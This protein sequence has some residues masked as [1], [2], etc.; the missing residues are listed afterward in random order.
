MN[1]DSLKI[2]NLNK[3][4]VDMAKSILKDFLEKEGIS[5]A[6]LARGIHRDKV[7]VNRW[8]N[9]T[10]SL[11]VDDANEIAKYVN[12]DVTEI[13][14]ERKM[15]PI[16][17][18]TDGNFVLREM[19]K[20]EMVS[21][22]REFWNKDIKAIQIDDPT[23]AMHNF[24]LLYQG[25]LKNNNQ[26]TKVSSQGFNKICKINISNV[27]KTTILGIPF[28]YPNRDFEILQPWSL[29]KFENLGKITVKD[30]TYCIPINCM[31]DQ[32]YLN[33]FTIRKL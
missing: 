12:C 16:T 18:R 6:D 3:I 33:N 13:L 17:F 31:F 22:P 19:S 11:S 20:P 14:H 25:N 29:N 9:D 7:T 21:V 30:M 8:V 10:R 32:T 28:F 27:K 2:I 1:T 24:I 15:S 26:L 4:K 5:Q 23:I